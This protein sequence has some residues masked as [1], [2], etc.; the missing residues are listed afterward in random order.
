[1]MVCD[2]EEQRKRYPACF[3][4]FLKIHLETLFWLHFVIVMCF[5]ALKLVDLKLLCVI[6]GPVNLS[7]FTV[8]R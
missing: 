5:S 6:Q 2:E 1:M 3:I 4:C 8:W 7:I